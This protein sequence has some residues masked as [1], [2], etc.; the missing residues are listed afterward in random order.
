[1]GKSENH[2][3]GSNNV[4]AFL[5]SQSFVSLDYSDTFLSTSPTKDIRSDSS[6]CL[7][8][9]THKAHAI[10]LGYSEHTDAVP[11]Y[12]RSSNISYVTTNCS[13]KTYE[14]EH[15]S[16]FPFCRQ[17]HCLNRMQDSMCPCS[18]LVKVRVSPHAFELSFLMADVAGLHGI[19]HTRS[20]GSTLVRLRNP[21]SLFKRVRLIPKGKAQTGKLCAVLHLF[22]P[23]DCPKSLTV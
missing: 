4:P 10:R 18:T 2:I 16:I 11:I 14:R 12:T 15:V 9:V 3:N 13:C 8:A 19:Q 21:W 17:P 22:L 20:R 5:W 23:Q 6:K 1:M 7:T